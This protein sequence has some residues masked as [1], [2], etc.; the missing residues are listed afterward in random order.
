MIWLKNKMSDKDW[1][2][3]SETDLKCFDITKSH[4]VRKG[5]LRPK[6]PT[7]SK[8]LTTNIPFLHAVKPVY[9]SQNFKNHHA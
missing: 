3:S 9:K 4:E 2:S 7:T 8:V 5:S 6:G 1:P